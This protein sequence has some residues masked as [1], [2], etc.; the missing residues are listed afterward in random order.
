[1]SEE[2][3]RI[4]PA[5]AAALG[6]RTGDMV[7]VTSRSGEVKVRAIV[8][9]QVPEGVTHM[10]FHFAEC[11][12]N[13]LVTADFA[14]LDPVTGTPAYKTIPV[15]AKKLAAVNSTE[16]IKAILFRAIQDTAFASR[17]KEKPAEALS[18]YNLTE[19]EKAALISGDTVKVE[20][21]TGKLDEKLATWLDTSEIKTA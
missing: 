9:E 4:N 20:S 6:I 18:S 21:F 1:M 7:Q 12:T 3:F 16:K 14:T 13:E 5:D 17:L 8:T 11:P 19:A 10:A 15:K 2:E